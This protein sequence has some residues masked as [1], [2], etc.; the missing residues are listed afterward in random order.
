MEIT[1]SVDK[2]DLGDY[3]DSHRDGDGDYVPA[4]TIGDEVVRQ[5][6]EKFSRS[7][8]WKGLAQRVHEIRDDEIRAQLAP[9]IAEALA[10]PI[11][12]TNSYGEKAGEDTTLREVIVA[13]ART[14][15]DTKQ[16]DRYGDRSSTT[17]LQAMIRAAVE[18]GFKTEIADAVKAAREAV[19]TEFGSS[20]GER[21]SGIVREALS[22]R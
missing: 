4:G 10:K 3:I 8:S 7:D 21:V 19:T 15:L 11:H 1:V 22:K 12:R 17:N 18:D 5:L 6:V 16:K 9:V 14:W 2:I 13:E 20:I